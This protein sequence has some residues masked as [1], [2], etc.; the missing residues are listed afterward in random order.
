[1]SD[2][3]A[4]TI[5]DIDA[6]DQEER[7]KL[8]IEAIKKE[9]FQPNGQPYLSFRQAGIEFNVPKS[10]L[11]DRFHGT[12]DRK[13]G[14]EK[15]R[16]LTAA[17][18]ETLVAWIKEMGWRGVPLQTQT[19][20]DYA[21]AIAGRPVSRKWIKRFRE[22]HPEIR[23][24]WTRPLEK[25][26]A[27]S[28]NPTAVASFFEVLQEVIETYDIP[29]ENIYNANEKGIQLGIGKKVLAFFDRD[30]KDVYSV[31]DGDREL[32]T[33]I[34]AVCADGTAIRPSVIFKAKRRDLEWGRINPCNA[35]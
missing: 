5:L 10:T 27:Q 28:L 34:E 7:L 8:A 1:M 19:V 20:I 16:A 33:V 26:R 18:E 24:R 13:D 2:Q 14:H 32:V 15:Q 12:K 22:R 31:E 6:L 35:R 11:Y 17:H 30:Q 4:S 9:G 29:P 21:S 3:P 25:C 23:A